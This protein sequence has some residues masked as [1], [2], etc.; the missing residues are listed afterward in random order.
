MKPAYI[1][2]IAILL[3]TAT[4]TFVTF[5]GAV[6]NRTSVGDAIKRPGKTVQV[7]GEI[8]KDSIQYDVTLNEL[9]FD[10]REL[11]REG[12]RKVVGDARM[13]IVYSGPK[14]ENFDDANSVEA[15]GA[16]RDGVFRANRLL[17][18]CPSKYNDETAPSYPAP[19]KA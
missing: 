6:A 3:V 14:P 1:L 5:A 11:T 8:V 9:R 2:A 17:V 16:Y 7:P 13:T 4:V 15:I 12:D 10:V 18:K 19:N